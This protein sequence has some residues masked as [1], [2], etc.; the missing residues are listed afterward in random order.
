MYLIA[1]DDN[2]Q[3]IQNMKI[4]Q[5]FYFYFLFR[6]KLM[7]QMKKMDKKNKKKKK[8]KKNSFAGG[9]LTFNFFNY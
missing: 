7:E 3:W 1:Y 2:V 6:I 8:Q 9:W 5:S 4:V